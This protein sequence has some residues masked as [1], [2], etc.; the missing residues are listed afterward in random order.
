MAKKYF[1]CFNK[2][3]K[4]MKCTGKMLEKVSRPVN[5]VKNLCKYTY[6]AAPRSVR[7]VRAGL[8]NGAKIAE[9]RNFGKIR[10]FI[11]KTTCVIKSVCKEIKPVEY[12]VLL[13]AIAIPLTPMGGSVVAFG[14]GC[15]LA[16]PAIIKQLVKG[17]LTFSDICEFL[18]NMGKKDFIELD[19]GIKEQVAKFKSFTKINK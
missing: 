5:V 11:K 4:I 1:C 2:G 7:I 10:T 16:M 9:E 17:E 19:P 8:E 13:S 12:P 6:N 18:R 14:A 3:M 15:V